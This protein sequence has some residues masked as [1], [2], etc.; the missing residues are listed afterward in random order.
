MQ[1]SLQPAAGTLPRP[2]TRALSPNTLFDFFRAT[3]STTSTYKPATIKQFLKEKFLSLQ[4]DHPSGEA[5]TMFNDEVDGFV[6]AFEDHQGSPARGIRYAAKQSAFRLAIASAGGK[7]F[8]LI[9]R[10]FE[11]SH[12]KG[13]NQIVID[14]ARE[15]IERTVNALYRLPTGSRHPSL[16]RR[17][18]AQHIDRVSQGDYI[19]HVCGLFN[20]ENKIDSIK[21]SNFIATLDDASSRVLRKNRQPSQWIDMKYKDAIS[22]IVRLFSDQQGRGL[23]NTHPASKL[24][25]SCTGFVFHPN[26]NNQAQDLL[27]SASPVSFDQISKTLASKYIESIQC[28]QVE[29]FFEEAFQR[30]DPCYE[31]TVENIF[32][33]QPHVSAQVIFHPRPQWLD[34]SSAENNIEGLLAWAERELLK[35]Y[36]SAKKF[37]LDGYSLQRVDDLLCSRDFALFFS[38]N[39]T[40]VRQR[41]LNDIK[42]LDVQLFDDLLAKYLADS[43]SFTGTRL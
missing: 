11:A 43:L 8:D 17:I 1:N 42:P 10:Y 26:R 5:L 36:A 28:T 2:A 6:S 14:Y 7:P 23:H 35:D 20:L 16:V 12:F 29:N 25:E 37:T 13:K 34:S 22:D 21:W 39:R 30:T 41:L 9:Q 40:L 27:N 3:C 4:Q 33:F 31:A 24:L 38:A 19:L 15:N 32:Q 18:T